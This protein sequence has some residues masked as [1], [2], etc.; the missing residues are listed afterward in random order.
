MD[1]ACQLMRFC[2]GGT[3]HSLASEAIET[4]ELELP[5]SSPAALVQPND[6]MLVGEGLTRI[7][8]DIVQ[9]ETVLDI[10]RFLLLKSFGLEE[11]LTLDPA[12]MNPYITALASRM[13]VFGEAWNAACARG[14]LFADV[15]ARTEA[16]DVYDVIH[17]E[18][19]GV[20]V[21]YVIND[22]RLRDPDPKPVSHS[23]NYSRDISLGS[24]TQL[25]AVQAPSAFAAAIFS[26]RGCRAVDRSDF[27]SKS[28]HFFMFLDSIKTLGLDF[29]V[30]LHAKTALPFKFLD[31]VPSPVIAELNNWRSME[32]SGS[33]EVASFLLE[34]CIH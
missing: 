15:K 14:I 28:M 6:I 10:T 27:T 1:V 19:A 29:A 21:A 24:C 17:A 11:A 8:G 9:A 12:A 23:I 22:E 33:L 30:A 18:P 31:S 20:G 26:E 25:L 13:R 7:F 5:H 34:S 16:F 4:G 2:N 32:D 3:L